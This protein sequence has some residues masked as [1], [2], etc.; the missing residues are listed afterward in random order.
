MPIDSTTKLNNST[1]KSQLDLS[2]DRSSSHP[3]MVSRQSV[4]RGLVIGACL[5]FAI[6]AFAGGPPDQASYKVL[7]AIVR[8]N[9][10]LFPVVAGRSFDTS[11]LL[12]LD[13]G[14]RSGQV[15]ISE[16]GDQ[17]GL[18]HPGQSLPPRQRGAEVNRLVLYNNSARPLLLLAGEIVTGGQQDRV[19]GSDRI[20]PPNTG[21]IDLSVFCVEPG[22]WT[23]AKPTFGSLNLQMAQP[24]VRAPAMA[25]QNQGLVWDNV[26][27][28]NAK[29]AAQLHGAESTAAAGTSSYAKVFASPPVQRIIAGYGGAEGEQEVMKELRSKGAV[30]VVVAVNG[31]VLWADVFANT[32]LL[33]KYWPKLM[34]SY[35]AEAMTAGSSGATPNLQDAEAWMSQMTG[36]REVAETEPGVY[37]RTDTTGDGFRVFELV[38]LL[39]GTGFSVHLTKIREENS[40]SPISEHHQGLPDVI[41]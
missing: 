10:A 35:V 19:I 32:D 21:P 14:I 7:S 20:V 1:R 9:L 5:A 33:A 17:P 41:R 28:S 6:P 22:R 29:A 37:R 4:L 24:D 39:R 36:N 13:E 27:N 26:R 30:G 23:G 40:G 8:N 18:V 25:E 11:Q 2:E 34:S 16:N 12:T 15:T 38:S 31:R 3:A